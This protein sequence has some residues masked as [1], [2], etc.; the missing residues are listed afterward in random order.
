MLRTCTSKSTISSINR[1]G[2][3]WISTCRR[4]KLDPCL[5]PNTK[6]NSKCIKN[7][8]ISP[9]TTK[10]K[11]RGKI[12]DI[13]ISEHFLHKTLKAQATEAIIY[14]WDYIKLKLSKQQ[15]K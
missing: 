4:I 2:K 11:Y 12:Q 13:V 3:N 15:R 5:S 6:T 9:E 10:R 1:A 8:N 7:L 14:K